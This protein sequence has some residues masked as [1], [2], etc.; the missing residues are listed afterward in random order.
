M[1]NERLRD[2][3]NRAGLTLVELAREVGVDPKTIERW[4]N[5]GRMPYPKHRAKIA[6]L[7]QES[8][9]YLWPLSHGVDRR[10][11]LWESEVVR[12]YPRRAEI[13]R[14]MWE[15]LLREAGHRID[16]LVYAG[17]FFPEQMPTLATTLCDK[18]AEGVEVRLLMARPDGEQVARRGEEEGIGDVVQGRVR[19]ALS[20]FRL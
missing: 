8:E 13:P 1:T 17:L 16:I 3:V 2:A 14:E 6:I 15:R 20:F 11:R 5:Q 9:A 7:L 18:V 10:A 19:N 12:F 4:I